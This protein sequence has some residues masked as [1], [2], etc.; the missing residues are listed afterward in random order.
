GIGAETSATTLQI[1][2]K[3]RDTGL[4]ADRDYLDRKPKAQFKT[5]N[6]LN[7]HMVITI[8]ESELADQTAHVKDMISGVE[9]T[10]PLAEVY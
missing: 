1:V 4:T 3:I 9:I 10:V 5:A 7:S 8:G 6:Q 2:E